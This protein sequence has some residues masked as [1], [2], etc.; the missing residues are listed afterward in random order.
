MHAHLASTATARTG[1]C[2]QV[3]QGSGGCGE[4]PSTT[5]AHGPLT[6]ELS[7]RAL[8]QKCCSFSLK[9]RLNI[10]EEENPSSTGILLLSLERAVLGR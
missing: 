7:G 3:G 9:G 8:G 4:P 6:W 2:Q 1:D 5:L 10:F